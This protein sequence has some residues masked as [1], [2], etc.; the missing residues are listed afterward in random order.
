MIKNR[1]VATENLVLT[2]DILNIYAKGYI[3]FGKALNFVVENE[4]KQSQD[5]PDSLQNSIIQV[6]AS[7][8][9]MIGKAY[10]TGTLS[11]P[12]WKFEYFSQLQ[13]SLGGQISNALKDIFE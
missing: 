6:M 11:K 1:K 3:D 12:S 2:G 7:F 10:L 13:N 8:G 4:V 5:Q 9:K